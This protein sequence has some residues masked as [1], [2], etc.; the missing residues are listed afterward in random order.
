MKKKADVNFE[1]NTKKK[2]NSI[3]WASCLGFYKIAKLLISKNALQNYLEFKPE[4]SQVVLGSNK[5]MKPN[6]LHWAC[7]KGN[8]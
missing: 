7:F 3:I 4:N 5:D 1:E 6:P 8:L 2:W